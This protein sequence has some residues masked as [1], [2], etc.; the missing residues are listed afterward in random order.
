MFDLRKDLK[1]YKSR[2][3]EEAKRLLDTVTKARE[4]GYAFAATTKLLLDK[5]SWSEEY[6][7]KCVPKNSSVSRLMELLK[8]D[9]NVRPNEDFFKNNPDLNWKTI[10]AGIEGE[11]ELP[12][13]S[14]TTGLDRISPQTRSNEIIFNSN[15][16]LNRLI[17]GDVRSRREGAAMARE[18]GR[19]AVW[20][21]YGV[22]IAASSS[23]SQY[24][25]S[26]AGLSKTDFGVYDL[27]SLDLLISKTAEVAKE[28]YRLAEHHDCRKPD[29]L[30]FL[31]RDKIVTQLQRDVDSILVN[32]GGGVPTRCR[33]KSSVLKLLHEALYP[34]K[35]SA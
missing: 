21:L 22:E 18:I 16:R 35:K 30:T 9:M 24:T 27:D 29:D 4:T 34:V 26:V 14:V 11:R 1:V 28:I 33:P 31:Q 19:I 3:Y 13:K 23:A 10:Q 5:S 6:K 7:V 17:S 15:S 32:Q 20:L 8:I 2:D 12:L 25:A